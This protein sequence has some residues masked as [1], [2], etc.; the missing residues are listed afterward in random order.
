VPVAIVLRTT[1]GAVAERHAGTVGFSLR[2][3]MSTPNDGSLMQTRE[4]GLVLVNQHVSFFRGVGDDFRR[5]A[6]HRELLIVLL[7]RE[8]RTRYKGARLGWIWALI[9]P[10]VMFG[11]YSVAV[12]I[13]LGAGR[14]IPEFGIYL[15]VGLI[16]WGFFAQIVQ[17]SIST[18][19][20]NAELIK[21]S[22]FPREL[23]IVAVVLV[24]LVDLAIQG[25]ILLV[26]YAAYGSFPS[27]SGL[28]WLPPALLITILFGTALGLWLAPVNVR[29]RD[30]GFVTDVGLQV[31][32]WLTPVLYSF[33]M[34]EDAWGSSVTAMRLYLLNPMSNAMFGFRAAL[35][36]AASTPE[37]AQFAFSGSLALRFALLFLIGLAACFLGWRFFARRSGNLAE[38]L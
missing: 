22:S 30:F 2:F 25:S 13:F 11:V 6:R 36:P 1:L 12:G 20:G 17:G 15:Y 23:L 34:V 5:I 8:F 9:R 19:I 14:A 35:W 4:E 24:A 3:P 38:E 31:G 29:I 32:F 18:L 33:A 27:V 26:G 10:L 37:G 7:G 28:I 16:A 21:K